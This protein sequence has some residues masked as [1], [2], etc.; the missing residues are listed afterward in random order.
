MHQQELEI[1]R[2]AAAE[3][4]KLIRAYRFNE[5]FGIQLK[6]KNDLVT[7]ADLASEKKILEVIK[8]AF[9]ED[10]F[11]AEESNKYTELPK[12]RVWIIDP[13]DG[14]TL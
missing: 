9:P 14:T 11:L 6:R 10:Q 1:A 7:D 3:A 8:S 13:I 4:A 2:K 12:G 5:S